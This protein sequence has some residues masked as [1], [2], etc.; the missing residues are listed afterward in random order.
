MRAAICLLSAFLRSVKCQNGS[1]S[2]FAIAISRLREALNIAYYLCAMHQKT[3]P[4]ILCSRHR[5]LSHCSLKGYVFD[6]PE[7]GTNYH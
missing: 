4:K 2:S 1:Q 5:M 7:I 6:F 3:S